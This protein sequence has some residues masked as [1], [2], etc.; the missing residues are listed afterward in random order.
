MGSPGYV[1]FTSVSVFNQIDY[2]FDCRFDSTSI[3]YKLINV[4]DEGFSGGHDLR[5]VICCPT[6]IST[7]ILGTVNL[8]TVPYINFVSDVS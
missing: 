5:Y 2:M 8:N 4:V 6:I 1:G 3:R 7:H